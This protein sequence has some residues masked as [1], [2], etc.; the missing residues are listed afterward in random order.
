MYSPMYNHKRNNLV[1]HNATTS[2]KFRNNEKEI[3]LEKPRSALTPGN[4][5]GYDRSL[6]YSKDCWHQLVVSVKNINKD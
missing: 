1:R 4:C 6:V 5:S 3:V 2:V